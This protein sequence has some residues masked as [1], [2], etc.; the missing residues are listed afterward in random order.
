MK[1]YS[2]DGLK[3]AKIAESFRICPDTVCDTLHRMETTFKKRAKYKER[4]ESVHKEFI[5]QVST[6]DPENIIYID[7]SGTDNN[8]VPIK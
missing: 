4:I 6:L 1:A 2:E 7:E 3:P 5:E 8:I